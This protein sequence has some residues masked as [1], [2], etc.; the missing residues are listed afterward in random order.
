MLIC[1]STIFSVKL[2]G[3]NLIPTLL[4]CV[5]NTLEKCNTGIWAGTGINKIN[6][7][8]EVRIKY[9]RKERANL[10]SQATEQ[11][12]FHVVSRSGHAAMATEGDAHK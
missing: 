1:F 12:A 8:G 11:K 6:L 7:E 2:K 9:H 5:S 3:P 10:L 4:V